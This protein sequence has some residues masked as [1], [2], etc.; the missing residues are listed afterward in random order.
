M[1]YLHAEKN[2]INNKHLIKAII[3][4]KDKVCQQFC[5]CM[6]TQ[7]QGHEKPGRNKHKNKSNYKSLHTYWLHFNTAY[8]ARNFYSKYT[9]KGKYD[10]HRWQIM[11][12]FFIAEHLYMQILKFQNLA[13]SSWPI[14]C[15][16]EKRKAQHNIPP[17]IILILILT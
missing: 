8:A 9:H 16:H 7:R 3:S 14:H 17:I 1:I 11:H 2:V 15:T 13:R 4:N 10:I 12:A 6:Q 5:T